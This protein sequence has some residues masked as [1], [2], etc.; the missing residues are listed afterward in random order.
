MTAA[1]L[2]CSDP[3]MFDKPDPDLRE[4]I[5]TIGLITLTMSYA[6]LQIE[7][8]VQLYVGEDAGEIVNRHLGP[9]R[10]KNGLLANLVAKM[11]TN[12]AFAKAIQNTLAAFAVLRENRNMLVHSHVVGTE[13]DG[14]LAWERISRNADVPY[15]RAI[16][17]LEDLQA[18]Y[19]EVKMTSAS[20]TVL[21]MRK[22]MDLGY[23]VFSSPTLQL[24][25]P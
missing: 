20:L 5:Y 9:N 13:P 12:D 8:L 7:H 1:S 11:E 24:G 25:L 10:S 17:N 16:A 6:E 15:A 22:A 21:F 18:M 23:A 19:A 14:S 4:H 2:S 3:C